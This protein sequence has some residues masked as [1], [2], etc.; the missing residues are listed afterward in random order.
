M[1]Q[2][3]VDNPEFDSV[4]KLWMKCPRCGNLDID[5]GTVTTYQACFPCGIFLNPDGHTNKMLYQGRA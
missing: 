5:H 1:Q 4:L 2:L 3:L